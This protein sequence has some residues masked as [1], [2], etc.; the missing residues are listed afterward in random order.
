MTTTALKLKRIGHVAVR[1]ADIPQAV[2]FYQ[3]LGM[4]AVW[5]DEDWA[6]VKAGADG[7][8]LLG[9]LYTHAGAHFGFILSDRAEL[10]SRFTT[11]TDQG[12]ACSP[13]LDHRDG[14]S[15]FYAKDR[16]G[17]LLEFLYEPS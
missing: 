14:T 1:V 4:E 16:D 5:Q 12:A 13:L 2:A 15:S 17:N 9:P 11:L 3:D 10:Q 6:Y 8:A 7:L